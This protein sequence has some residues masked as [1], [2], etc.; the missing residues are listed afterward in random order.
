[1]AVGKV[2]VVVG[3]G[4]LAVA[5]DWWQWMG[6]SGWVAVVKWQWM[7]GSGS[8]Y[9]QWQWLLAVAV[10]MGRVAVAGWQWQG[11]SG[12]VAVDGWQWQWLGGSGSGIV[13]PPLP[14]SRCHN[15]TATL[16][17]AT[18]PTL[19]PRCHSHSHSN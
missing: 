10:G 3:S 15:F 2:A 11:G 18:F 8:G 12:G 9:W 4:L 7:G 5:V 1:V 19:Q 14:R 16:P 13:P 6:G 17:P